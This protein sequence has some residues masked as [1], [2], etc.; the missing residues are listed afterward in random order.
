MRIRYHVTPQP[1]NHEHWFCVLHNCTNCALGHASHTIGCQ[2]S[3]DMYSNCRL[4][5]AYSG[6]RQKS[7]ALPQWRRD[8]S[9][10]ASCDVVEA[11]CSLNTRKQSRCFR[12][13][14]QRQKAEK[15]L[16]HIA[17]VLLSNPHEHSPA[18]R[19][20]SARHADRSLPRPI[21][22]WDHHSEGTAQILS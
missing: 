16:Q 21:Y 6:R 9:C 18:I 8:F 17:R 15:I 11:E 10:W 19:Q 4:I 12:E 3:A 1:E 5:E 13:K 22:R 14:E 20:L 2:C 7:F